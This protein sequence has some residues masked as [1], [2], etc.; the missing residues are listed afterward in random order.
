MGDKDKNKTVKRSKCNDGNCREGFIVESTN[1]HGKRRL[2]LRMGKGGKW[3][4]GKKRELGN[5]REKMV[6]E[7]RGQWTR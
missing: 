3:G 5:G 6:G 4:G 1:A 2:R 7:R